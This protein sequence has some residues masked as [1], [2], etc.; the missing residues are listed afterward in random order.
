VRQKLGG[1]IALGE[2]D[3]IVD[4]PFGNRVATGGEITA[5]GPDRVRLDILHRGPVTA[6]GLAE[7]SIGLDQPR[8]GRP[9]LR[10]GPQFQQMDKGIQRL[11][12]LPQGISHVFGFLRDLS[13]IEAGPLDERMGFRKGI[14]LDGGTGIAS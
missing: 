9:I 7:G 8:S 5:A 14:G 3:G 13:Q 6:Q 2:I 11:P 4:R 1:A 12:Y 10:Q